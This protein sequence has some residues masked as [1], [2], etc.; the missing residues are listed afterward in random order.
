MANYSNNL[1]QTRLGW[2]TAPVFTPD[3]SGTPNTI[4]PDST[5]FI[6]ASGISDS[7]QISAIEILVS[8]LK[9]YGLW[10]KMKAIYPFVG[11]SASSHKFNLKDPRN[12]DAAY[13]LVFNGGWTH[14]INGALPNGTT[15]YA[16]TYYNPSSLL[17]PFI[18]YYSRSNTNTNTDQI[19][20]GCSNTGLKY[21][22]VSA[23][24]KTNTYNNIFARNSSASV[25]LDGGSPTDSRG[26]YWT[27]KISTTAK[28]GK[29][30][31]LLTSSTDTTTAPNVNIFIGSLGNEYGSGQYFSNR[32]T[33]FSIIGD[34]LTDTDTSNLY[35]SV[36]K[37]QTTLG[38][39][40]GTPY[41]SD[42]DAI[43]FLMA[44]G[45]TDGTQ[46]AAINTLVIRMKADGVWTKMK[47][48]YPFVG[49]NATSHKFN[50]KDPRDLDAAF[51]L[52]FNGGI[53]HTYKGVLFNG[54]TG[55]ADTKLSPNTMGLNSQHMSFYTRIEGSTQ[56]GVAANGYNFIDT[57]DSTTFRSP[58]NLQNYT[59]VSST[60]SSRI[61]FFI[62]N[63]NTSTN[64]SIYKDVNKL[65]D[66]FIG[67]QYLETYPIYIS[68]LNR[69]T[70]INI[71]AS[72]E[73]IF[74]TIGDGLNDLEAKSLY[75]SV[76]EFQTTLGRQVNIPVVSD[77]DAQAFLNA[78]NITSFQQASAV[79][80]LVVDLKAAGV[81]TKMKAIYPFVGGSAA[82]HKFNLKD[83]RD[84]DAAYRL[85]FNGG[86]THTG[87]GA[88][89]NGTT[90][91]A[92][93]KMNA[94]STNFDYQS[95]SAT[96]YSRTNNSLSVNDIGVQTGSSKRFIELNIKEGNLSYMALSHQ[97]ISYLNFTNNDSRGFYHSNRID[98]NTIKLYKNG[99]NVAT[100]TQTST[101]IYG[102]YS[103]Y[104]SAL[105]AR[106]NNNQVLYF[107]NREVSFTTLGSGLTDAEATSLY[108]AVQTYQTA[109]GRAV[110]TPVYNNG[111][112]LN[113]DAG[114]ANSY[115]G[116][117]TTWFDLAAGN[118][119]TLVNGPTYN[120]TNGGSISFDG[121]NDYV[122]ITNKV[123]LNDTDITYDFWFRTNN[124]DN[125]YQTLITQIDGNYVNSI[126]LQ[127]SRS[128]WGTAPGNVYFQVQGNT[129]LSTLNG[130]GLVAAGIINYTAVAKKESGF[131]KLYLYRNGVLDNSMNTSITTINMSTWSNLNTNIGRN[132]ANNGGYA[133]YLNGNIYSGKVWSRSLSATEIL[134]NFNSTRGRFGL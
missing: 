36:Q 80:K 90:G 92:D 88:L 70:S 33:G 29:N 122:N 93:T 25:L 129:L 16:N 19:D 100:G 49:G 48:I 32:E 24:Y 118:N 18:G 77:T 104:I 126:A 132:S 103:V 133:E 81:W 53:T 54:T 23:W 114:N 31:S 52:V 43:A 120:S 82:S 12:L 11:G 2:R 95:M 63:R 76:Q 96:F 61:G 125:V 111:L 108:N 21:L 13:R 117:G 115:P 119:G 65:N 78:A 37:F 130:A 56:M 1:G 50:L 3:G 128:G 105:N 9:A 42:P 46:A 131:Y 101:N 14:T 102:E 75:N 68:G 107:S 35:I 41:V 71:S 55:Y 127:K 47:A 45:I 58:I 22:Y 89:P 91:Y 87:T 121:I 74:S 73:Y 94:N 84:L 10:T 67:S 134:N 27:N 51:R 28:L 8:D 26:W 72:N 39:H 79:N 110:D 17:N 109:L 30:G 20:M 59:L 64:I 69:N 113:L 83:P 7:L 5:N 124:N 97:G 123:T 57:L 6:L 86:W 99:T 4:D 60:I 85:V 40:V 38:R 44:A 66:N 116:T 98:S 15:G 62:G 106:H 34:G 112:V